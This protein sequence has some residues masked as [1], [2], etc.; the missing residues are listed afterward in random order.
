MRVGPVH[1][2]P[3]DSAGAEARRPSFSREPRSRCVLHAQGRVGAFWSACLASGGGASIAFPAEGVVVRTPRARPPTPECGS[4]RQAV[5]RRIRVLAAAAVVA[6]GLL[7]IPRAVLADELHTPSAIAVDT[8]WTIVAAVLV[9]FMQAGFAML[10][11]GFS[12]M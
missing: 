11:V 10:E 8:V 4:G 1:G 6:A 3:P 5:G 2:D 9:L 7:L 12:R